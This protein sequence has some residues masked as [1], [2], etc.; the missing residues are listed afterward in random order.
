VR[1]LT[2]WGLVLLVLATGFGA[3][4]AQGCDDCRELKQ[5]YRDGALNRYT[6]AAAR[7]TATPSVRMILYWSN[8][9]GDCDDVLDGVLPRLQE[10]YGA[11]LEVRL[12]EVVSME[13]IS[14]FFDVAESY[15][16]ARGKAAVP[17]LLIGER[18]LSG[19]EQ[20]EA[21]LP[22]L[23]DA[24]LVA[25]EVDWPAPPAK[26]TGQPGQAATGGCDFA[27]PCPDEPKATKAPTTGTAQ[28]RNLLPPVAGTIGLAAVL[29]GSLVA[30]R[31][32]RATDRAAPNNEANTIVTG[33][34]D[35]T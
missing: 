32:H 18:A 35:A 8:E 11:Q 33:E 4:A 16:F 9:C 3:A 1:A 7:P 31:R 23:I 34:N 30:L 28:P 12:V 29:G 14:A 13:E 19:V 25:G 2:I 22:Q 21:E 24:R 26:G 20:I 17:F 15:G 10:H 6:P 27:T 5:E